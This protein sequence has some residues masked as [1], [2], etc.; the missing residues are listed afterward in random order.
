MSLSERLNKAT[1]KA[2][3][4]PCPIAVILRSLDEANAKALVEALECSVDSPDRL[5]TPAI[6]GALLEEGFSVHVKGIEKHRRHTC[7]CWVGVPK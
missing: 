5:T 2:H 3:G 1:N 4:L 6:Q 7:R